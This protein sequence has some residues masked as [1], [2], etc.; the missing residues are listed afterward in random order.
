MESRA[1]VLE[2]S[3]SDEFDY[4]QLVL[5][6]L[7]TKSV[8]YDSTRLMKCSAVIQAISDFIPNTQYGPDVY[9]K[10]HYEAIA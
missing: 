9:R 5:N 1:T 3:Q 4:Q 6:A 10:M 7:A 8:Y 2:F